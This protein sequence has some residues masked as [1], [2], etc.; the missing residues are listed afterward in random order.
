MGEFVEQSKGSENWWVYWSHI[1]RF[2]YVY[3]YASGLIISKA[4]QRNVKKNPDYIDKV[5]EFLSTGIS[6]SPREI[7]LDIGL[8]ISKKKFWEEGL[9]EI[10]DLLIETENLARKLGKIN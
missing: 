7:F 6:K 9:K 10:E 2:F 1:R 3:S 8:D 5:Q 4:L